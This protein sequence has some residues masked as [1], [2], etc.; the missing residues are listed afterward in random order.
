MSRRTLPLPKGHHGDDSCPSKQCHL[1]Q[2]I[3]EPGSVG[4]GHQQ[5]HKGD[6]KRIPVDHRFTQSSQSG[7]PA[8][9][10]LDPASPRL[11]AHPKPLSARRTVIR[12]KHPK[13][14]KLAESI[15][16]RVFHGRLFF[17]F[18]REPE[19]GAFSDGALHP[20]FTTHELRQLFRD[21]QTQAG[22]TE[23]AR[24]GLVC[25]RERLEEEAHPIHRNADPCIRDG[26]AQ[27]HR[28]FV[29]LK[30]ID[31]NNNFSLLGELD[32]IPRQVDKDLA[33]PAGVAPQQGRDF[34]THD[35]D[36]LEALF[37]RADGQHIH[38]FFHARAQIK[39]QTLQRQLAGFDLGEVQNVVDEVQQAFRA[40]SGQFGVL[41]LLG[42][43]LGLQEQLR[44][45]NDTVHGGSD[46]MT[47]L[48]QKLRLGN[49]GQ[50]GLNG[51]LVGAGDG[52]LQLL[53]DLLQL[54]L[55]AF[56]VV[57]D[58]LGIGDVPKSGM[59]D[60]VAMKRDGRQHDRCGEFTAVS[61]AALPL[62]AEMAFGHGPEKHFI[63][64]VP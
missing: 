44:H 49:V 54:Q 41:S 25:L 27:P 51:H 53:V 46:L 64:F 57:F 26:T 61:P 8:I 2:R 14:A 4:S 58:P 9:G 1:L 52:L 7:G 63:A 39:I 38:G 3:A 28:G 48:R 59:K 40:R 5:V 20:D 45:S 32:C 36:Q 29:L 42:I 19:P 33:Q 60:R 30:E 35:A 50:L 17:Q 37:A 24:G 6:L 56:Q 13:V 34:G 18:H 23:F 12:N 22:S 47:H 43:Q 15:L 21:R 10:L 11:Q 31:T 55:R 62:K 16:G